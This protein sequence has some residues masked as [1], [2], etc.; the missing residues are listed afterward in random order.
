MLLYCSLNWFVRTIYLVSIHQGVLDT[1]LDFY[2]WH[3]LRF[4]PRSSPSCKIACQSTTWLSNRV[5]LNENQVTSMIWFRN[6]RVLITAQNLS[7]YSFGSAITCTWSLMPL[8]GITGWKTLRPLALCSNPMRI[9]QDNT[10][11]F[12]NKLNIFVFVWELAGVFYRAFSLS[13]K[14]SGP[15]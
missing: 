8:S 6:F 9:R 10:Y 5:S 7:C 3:S 14:W 11:V 13:S 4:S 15:I 1:S 12:I 2:F